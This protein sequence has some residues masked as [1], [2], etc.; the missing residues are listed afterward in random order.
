MA[1]AA[2]ED[3]VRAGRARNRST[4]PSRLRDSSETRLGCAHDGFAR[5]VTCDKLWH[6]EA[7]TQPI[8]RR[9]ASKQ[10]RRAALTAAA[11]RLFSERGYEATT[12]HDIAAA[13]GLTERTFYRYFDGK[14][15]LLAE[16]YQALLKVLG[17]AI[18]SRPA[19][20]PPFTAIH[21]A[22]LATARHVA[23]GQAGEQADPAAMWLFNDRPFAG[24]RRLAPRPLLRLE[25]VVADATLARLR[26]APASGPEPADVRSP[27]SGPEEEYQA[28]VI[29]RVA[30]AALRSAVVRHRHLVR[31]GEPG[32]PSIEYLLGQAFVIIGDQRTSH[33]DEQR[34]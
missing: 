30:V 17:D 18:R 19:S 15:G 34:R 9:E 4:T 33:R 28:Q 6:H 27:P 5:R 16:E 10:A 2:G 12:V 3:A 26:A 21:R 13:A 31:D 1:G 25:T 14:E 22:M 11:Y 23:T 8:G 24:L 20:E 32:P 29:A 7:M